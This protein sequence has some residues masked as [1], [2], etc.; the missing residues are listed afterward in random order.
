MT[1]ITPQYNE[2]TIYGIHDN[3]VNLDQSL[4]QNDLYFIHKC[5]RWIT[6]GI[7]QPNIKEISI[8]AAKRQTNLSVLQGLLDDVEVALREGYYYHVGSEAL[9]QHH[10][11]MVVRMKNTLNA[12]KLKQVS[13]HF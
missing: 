8:A 7:E 2:V 12:V 5:V 3:L 13:T 4:L 1:P 6:N 9:W 10:G 11:D